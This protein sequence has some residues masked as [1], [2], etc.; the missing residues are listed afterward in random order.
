MNGYIKLLNYF[1][2]FC[3]VLSPF[4]YYRIAAQTAHYNVIFV[5]K[6]NQTNSYITLDLYYFR[7]QTVSCVTMIS[8][9]HKLSVQDM[10]GKGQ[11]SCSPH[12]IYVT[13]IALHLSCTCKKDL[14]ICLSDTKTKLCPA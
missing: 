11:K 7:K 5:V 3:Y 2:L 1:I 14:I 8:S 10:C 6:T 13:Y 12:T 4:L 9:V